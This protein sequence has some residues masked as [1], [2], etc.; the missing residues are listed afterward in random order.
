[1]SPTRIFKSQRDNGTSFR[2][3]SNCWEQEQLWQVNSDEL[4]LDI[5]SHVF[6][7]GIPMPK[8]PLLLLPLP[9]TPAPGDLHLPT[10]I[11]LSHADP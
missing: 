1:M 8:A 11:P 9:E 5:H 4:A 3:K 7:D 2:G 6:A 10:A